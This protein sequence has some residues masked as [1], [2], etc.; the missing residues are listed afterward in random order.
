MNYSE[1]NIIF[2]NSRNCKSLG[3]YTDKKERRTADQ[4][5]ILPTYICENTYQMFDYLNRQREV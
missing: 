5:R 1:V 2:Q 4:K 3:K